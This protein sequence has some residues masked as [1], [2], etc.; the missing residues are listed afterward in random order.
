RRAGAPPPP[1][2]AGPPARRDGSRQSRARADDLLDD[3]RLVGPAHLV[4]QERHAVDEEDPPDDRVAETAAQRSVGEGQAP[5]GRDALRPD[6][7]GT[8]PD[9]RRGPDRQRRRDPEDRGEL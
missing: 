6:L 8:E 1:T 9:Q 5:A 3:Q 4:R 2:P 7:L